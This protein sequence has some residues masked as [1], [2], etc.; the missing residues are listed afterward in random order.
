VDDAVDAVDG[1]SE[2]VPRI[3]LKLH[4]PTPSFID[5]ARPTVLCIDT[6]PPPD[7][8]VFGPEHHEHHHRRRRR[9]HH[10]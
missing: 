8:V 1:G 4:L 5:V 6:G 3:G 10:H 7:A 9:R 2:R